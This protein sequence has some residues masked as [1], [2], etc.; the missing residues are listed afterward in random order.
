ME[1]LKISGANQYFGPPSDWQDTYERACGNLHVRVV[2]SS[3][4]SAWRP[5]PD[6][7]AVLNAG[8]SVILE[9]LGGQPPVALW[10]SDAMERIAN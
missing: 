8:G 10:V 3:C 4:Q 5:T 2:G 7:L 1:P 9:I 6:E